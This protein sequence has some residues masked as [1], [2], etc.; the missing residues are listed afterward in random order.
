MN[1]SSINPSAL[2]NSRWRWTHTSGPP[3][4]RATGAGLV[5]S[6][7]WVGSA[8]MAMLRPPLDPLR[9]GGRSLASHGL[10][11]LHKLHGGGG[12]TP[13]FAHHLTPSEGRDPIRHLLRL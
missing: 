7:G 4:A 10:H 6:E 12:F 11:E 8:R 1:M 3:P 5:C 13:E 2:A 9:R